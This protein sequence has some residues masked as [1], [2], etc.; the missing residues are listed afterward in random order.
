[1]AALHRSG[2]ANL[3][4]ADHAA[5]GLRLSDAY[6]LS[7]V[8]C[9]PPDN[10]PR[11]EE[12]ARC[13]RHLDQEVEALADVQVVVALGKIAFDAWVN[14]MRRQGLRLTPR[15][16]FGHGIKVELPAGPAAIRLPVLLGC[17]HPSRQNTN[18]GKL[19]PG[20]MD[21]VLRAAR[22]LQTPRAVR[23]SRTR[24]AR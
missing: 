24:R 14:W 9:A 3:P 13:A 6:I 10:K 17:Y 23:R 12:I 5:D 15:P 16:T 18:T 20:M 2:F 1:M 19:T 11:P 22:G 4:T 8:R 7:A 21:D